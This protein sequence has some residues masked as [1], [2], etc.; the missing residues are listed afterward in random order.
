MPN[1]KLDNDLVYRIVCNDLCKLLNRGLKTKLKP[2]TYVKTFDNK[3][4]IVEYIFCFESKNSESI[5]MH[6]IP[7]INQVKLSLY[8]VGDT[9][10]TNNELKDLE[11]LD[12]TTLIK[13]LL[14]KYI[15]NF[16]KGIDSRCRYG[17]AHIARIKNFQKQLEVVDKLNTIT[18]L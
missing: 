7:N 18:K 11:F 9:F 17:K 10:L 6:V 2:S 8:K 13:T 12:I 14:T 5:V 4:Y 3:K 16:N 15:Y 1:N